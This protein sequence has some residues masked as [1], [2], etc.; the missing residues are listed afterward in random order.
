MI[1]H[2]GDF[3]GDITIKKSTLKVFLG[4]VFVAS[5]VA[6]FVTGGFGL[7]GNT[8][9]V[10]GVAK[11]TEGWPRGADGV[12]E[13]RTTIQDFQYNPDVI[14]VNKGDRIRLIIENKDNVVH[15]LHLPQFGIVDSQQPL[16]TKVVEFTAIVT[17]G[18]GQALRT[19]SLEHGETLTFNV[20]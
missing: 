2:G 6:A 15:G 19:C 14:T 12:V 16:N 4:V 7:T 8:V 11:E 9:S 17:Q 13:V 20:V 1:H 5:I 18:N 10:D 3:M